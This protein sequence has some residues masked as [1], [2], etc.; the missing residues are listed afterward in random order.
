MPIDWSGFKWITIKELSSVS[1]AE[2]DFG[3]GTTHT[4]Y[5]SPG[6]LESELGRGVWDSV[7]DRGVFR[8]GRL[9]I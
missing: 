3:R 6:G 4:E 8:V 2:R 1:Y 5:F 7:Q 9:V